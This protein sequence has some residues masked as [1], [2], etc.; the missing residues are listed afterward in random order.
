MIWVGR[1]LE[2]QALEQ[3]SLHA[4]F[5]TASDE[6]REAILE[7]HEAKLLAAARE[8]RRAELEA[9]ALMSDST[10]PLPEHGLIIEAQ[11]N[12]GRHKFLSI[13]HP[14]RSQAY[15]LREPPLAR[16]AESLEV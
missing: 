1:R 12:A 15:P 13:P 5:D 16:T 2:A 9:A 4:E 7:E 8:L 3:R 14:R 10:G 11:P 6:R